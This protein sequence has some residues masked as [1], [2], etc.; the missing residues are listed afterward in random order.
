MVSHSESVCWYNTGVTTLLEAKSLAKHYG[1][2]IAL[3][4]VDFEVQ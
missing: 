3:D 2:I 4:S 1:R